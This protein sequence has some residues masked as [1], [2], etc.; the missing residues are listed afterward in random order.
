MHDWTDRLAGAHA[1]DIQWRY[2][3][4]SH[5]LLTALDKGYLTYDEAKHIINFVRPDEGRFPTYYNPKGKPLPE[6]AIQG[7]VSL[8]DLLGKTMESHYGYCSD[9]WVK[10]HLN[11][12]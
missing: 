1:D 10:I 7:S 5:E 12:Y 11:N 4:L 9:E 3:E 8:M 2:D 6:V